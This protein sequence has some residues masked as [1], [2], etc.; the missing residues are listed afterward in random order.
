MVPTEE[1]IMLFISN[2]IISCI[3]RRWI[4]PGSLLV[5][6]SSSLRI[7]LIDL[8]FLR[9]SFIGNLLIIYSNLIIRIYD[10]L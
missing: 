9:L 2:H 1:E 3:S 10:P 8:A 4:F 5:V 7:T 6:L